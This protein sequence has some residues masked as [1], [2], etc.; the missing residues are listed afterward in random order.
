MTKENCR[1]LF[2]LV[3]S[4]PVVNETTG[5]VLENSSTKALEE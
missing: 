2:V 4:D 3:P 1:M 5:E